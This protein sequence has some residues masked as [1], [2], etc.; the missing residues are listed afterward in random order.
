M[1]NAVPITLPNRQKDLTR[2]TMLAGLGFSTAAVTGPMPAFAAALADDTPV[3][4]GAK[5][6]AH[7]ILS[8]P[9]V[10]DVTTVER[11]SGAAP[12]CFWQVAPTGDY[13]ADCATGARY[14][15]A[16]LDYMVAANTPQVLQW[17]VFDMMT[18]RRHR[19]GIE[20]G[21]LST[22]GR[23]ATRAHATRLSEGGLA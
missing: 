23:I 2:R 3:M 15:A 10:R 17:A 21:F 6:L 19:S 9:F 22:F 1:A 13:G 11:A 14:A 7:P 20:V 12:R 8:L 16:A 5:H 4:P 18:M